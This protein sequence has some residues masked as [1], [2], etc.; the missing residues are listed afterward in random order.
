M[1]LREAS[2]GLRQAHLSLVDAVTILSEVYASLTGR[3]EPG[4]D[5]TLDLEAEIK[6]TASLAV[7]EMRP[8]LAVLE[9]APIQPA[10][11]RSEGVEVFLMLEEIIGRTSAEQRRQS[12]AA[13]ALRDRVGL[14]AAVLKRW[15]DQFAAVAAL[16]NQDQRLASE[17]LVVIEEHLD[18]AISGLVKLCD[19]P[20]KVASGLS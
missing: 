4:S 6:S 5:R 18:P 11:R 7:D 10:I 8:V 13:E 19:A 15:R 9:R 14:G 17:L 3:F 20:G 16:D 2:E 1:N 12:Q